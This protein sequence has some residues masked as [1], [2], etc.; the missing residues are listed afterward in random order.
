MF[1]VVVSVEADCVKLLLAF[2]EVSE[3]FL[4][5]NSELAKIDAERLALLSFNMLL[6]SLVELTNALFTS[7]EVALIELAVSAFVALITSR[8]ALIP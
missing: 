4:L 2:L 1:V 8:V 7:P 6:L 5:V 3:I